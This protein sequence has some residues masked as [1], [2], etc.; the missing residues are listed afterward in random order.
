MGLT[1]VGERSSDCDGKP[2][3]RAATLVLA[4]RGTFLLL[5]LSHPP[6]FKCT[7]TCSRPPGLRNVA[8]YLE[9]R[10]HGLLADKYVWPKRAFTQSILTASCMRT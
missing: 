7:P 1:L 2:A 6:R 9:Q 5:A 3:N 8:Q 10:V 4:R